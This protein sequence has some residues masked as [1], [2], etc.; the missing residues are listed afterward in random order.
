VAPTRLDPRGLLRALEGERGGEALDALRE[1][2]VADAAFAW[3]RDLF[4]AFEEPPGPRR[5]ARVNEQLLD[6]ESRMTLWARVPRVCASIATTA[7]LLFG[8]IA[9]LAGMGTP[10]DADAGPA[11]NDALASA[12][13]ALSV[14]I[15]GTAFCIAVHM[16]ARR[17]AREERAAMEAL[18]ERLER[19]RPGGPA[20]A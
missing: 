9:M 13:G 6:L 2:T 11:L 15:A 20:D 3:E 17:A 19:L 14:G 18:L 8:S 5:D 16:R 7:G 1:V 4:A 12:L 10:G